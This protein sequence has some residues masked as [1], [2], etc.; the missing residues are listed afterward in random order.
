MAFSKEVSYL[1]NRGETMGHKSPEEFDINIDFQQFWLILKRR[2]LPALTIFSGVVGLSGLAALSKVP[3]YEAQGS[4]QVVPD[5]TAALTGVGKES[6]NLQALSNLTNPSETEALVVRSYTLLAEVAKT[7]KLKDEEGKPVSA[8]AL[9]YGLAITPVT[10]TD[11]IR[12]AYRDRDPVKAAAVVNTLI[13]IYI[14]H[15]IETNRAEASAARKFIATQLPKIE[16]EVSQAEL[17]LRRFKEENEIVSLEN[18]AE[19]VAEAIADLNDKLAAK[20]AEL[21]E[22]TAR[23]EFLNSKIGLSPEE[24]IT[25]NALSQSPGVQDLLKK[26]QDVETELEEQRVRFTT[27]NPF[28]SKLE[29]KKQRLEALLRTRVTE[30]VDGRVPELRGGLQSGEHEQNL[31]YSLVNDTANHLALRNSVAILSNKLAVYQ[32][33]AIQLPRLEQRQQEL[34]R[35]L[36]A[37]KVTYATLLQRLQEVSIAE[38]QNVGNARIIDTAI[39]PDSPVSKRKILYVAAGFVLGTFMGVSAALILELMDKSV[40]T[41][42]EAKELFGYT[43]LG[44]IPL[45]S[46]ASKR[47]HKR[48]E[49][50]EEP[51]KI[52]VLDK[53]RSPVSDAYRMLQA[54]LKFLSSDDKIRVIAVTSSVRGEGKS[55]TAANLAVAL[56]ELSHRVLLVEG[57]MRHPSQ[58]HFWHLNN[59]QGLSNVLVDQIDVEAAIQPVL[60]NVDVILSGVCPPNPFALLHSKRMAFLVKSFAQTY[61]Y[62]IIDTPALTVAPDAMILGKMT[63]GVLVVVRPGVLERGSVPAVQESLKKSSQNVLGLVVNGI[64]LGNEPDGYYYTKEY[65]LEESESTSLATRV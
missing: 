46:K 60:E 4:L 50:E 1:K 21:G 49:L 53:P 12:V 63:D 38:N 29:E 31:R 41:V 34:D 11:A 33:R 3:T 35:R 13:E 44:I 14:K 6:T 20:Q 56:S 32:Q 43:L 45:W 57:D 15:N 5:Q 23:V 64:I 7:L 65:Y 61:D 36:E 24:A 52:P 26:L 30:V 22:A 59:T 18:E 39:V 40:K 42:K 51:I 27:Q 58:H 62:V 19:S 16:T 9:A 28:I 2:W 54:N 48:G 17:S 8:K 25:A 10:E 47:K 55:T 37:A